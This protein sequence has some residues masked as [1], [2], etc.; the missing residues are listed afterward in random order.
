VIKDSAMTTMNQV[1]KNGVHPARRPRLAYLLSLVVLLLVATLA[2]V[3]D[4]VPHEAG[5]EGLSSSRWPTVTR[6]AELLW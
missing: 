5:P 2:P 1:N 3:V 4:A 6:V